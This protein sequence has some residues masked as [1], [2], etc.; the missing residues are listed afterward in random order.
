MMDVNPSI[1]DH[2]FFEV[3]P[4]SGAGWTVRE[5]KDSLREAVFSSSDSMD[6]DLSKLSTLMM[7]PNLSGGLL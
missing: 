6:T 5:L 1:E 3:E 2:S 7:N 4:F